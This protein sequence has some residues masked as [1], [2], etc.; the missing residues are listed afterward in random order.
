MFIELIATFAIGF[1]GAGIAL[2]ANHLTGKRLPRWIIPVMAGGAMI[3]FTIFNEY[4][5]YTRTAN[6]LPEGIHVAKKVEQSVF[7]RPWTYLVPYV[8]RFIAV[9]KLS[10]RK[11]DKFPN[12]RILDL[13]IYGRWAPANRIKAIFD[14][15]NGK[16]ADLTDG[17]SFKEDGSLEGATWYETGK[18]NP[19]TK[20]A[21]QNSG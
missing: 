20:T 1:A 12:Q 21:C 13:L 9:D 19:V 16:R 18:D 17:V 8:D 15:E 10:V 5:W 3:S 2:I 6:A 7:Y 14:C 11:N 4:S